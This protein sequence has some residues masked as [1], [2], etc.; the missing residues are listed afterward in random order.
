MPK[1]SLLRFVPFVIIVLFAVFFLSCKS[2]PAATQGTD[3]VDTLRFMSFNIL[4][5]GDEVDFSKVVEAIALANPDV[6]GL[7]EAEGATQ[8]LAEALH[9]PYYDPRL[10]ILSKYPLIRSFDKGWYYTYVETSPGKGFVFSNIHLP[11]DPYG[12]E[13]VRDGKPVDSVIQNEYQ[14]RFHELD[15]HKSYFSALQS[16]GFPIVLT[17]DFNAPSHSDWTA[18]LVGARPH[19]KY[20]V[21]WPVSKSLE[22]MGF[23]D[24]Y[25]AIFPDPKAKPGLTWTPGFPAPQTKANETHDR[26]DFIWASKAEKILDAKILGEANG[27]D[28]DMSVTPYPSD[29]RAVV[30]DCIIRPITCPDYIQTKDRIFHFT[31]T[32]KLRYC[33]NVE[34]PFQV[35]LKDNKGDTIATIESIKPNKGELIVRLPDAATKNIEVFLLSKSIVRAR[36]NFWRRESGHHLPQL[37]VAKIEFREREPISVIWENSPG[38]RFDWIAVYPKSANTKADYG[39]TH[40]Q[41]QYLIYKYTLGQVSGRLTLDSLSKGDFWPLPAGEYILHL[42]SDDGFES[43][44]SRPIKIISK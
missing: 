24:A 18:Q 34:G 13:L 16:A 2:Q 9:Y 11:S 14:T 33:S 40:Q 1:S 3:D 42:L 39:M 32:I 44:A 19:M 27:P 7:Q 21:E 5:G 29:H 43:L 4:Y 36:G 35:L 10:H 23:V 6:V 12:P 17:G 26:I 30:I 38:D 20:A 22:Q 28:V 41:S 25:R 31:D 37:I 15:T 8:K